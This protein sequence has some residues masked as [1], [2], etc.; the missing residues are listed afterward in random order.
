MA[1]EYVKQ[2]VLGIEQ[3]NNRIQ[4]NQISL[5]SALLVL[6][7]IARIFVAFRYEINWDEFFY[8]SLIYKFTNND[9]YA[10]LQTFH[11]HFFT[12]LTWITSN[13]VNQ[14]ISARLIMLLLQ[15]GTVFIIY[16]ISC[17]YL[18]KPAA[19]FA[20]L[21][22][23]AVSYNIRMGAS[24]RADP[25]ATFCLM[26]SLDLILTKCINHK[27]AL[28]AGSLIAISMMITIKSSLYL[29]T[30]FFITVALLLVSDKNKIDWQKIMMIIAASI[31]TFS[32]LYLY[33]KSS[34]SVIDTT[35]AMNT[36][37]DS[38]DKTISHYQLLPRERY[39]FNSFKLDIVYWLVLLYGLKT[40]CLNLYVP[41]ILSRQ[42]SMILLSLILPLCSVLFYRNAFPY[43]YPFML[44]PA[45]II[46]GVAWHS[47]QWNK[48]RFKESVAITSFVMFLFGL[49]II[50]NGFIVPHKKNL[51]RQREL[52]EVV[53]RAFPKPMPYFDRCSMIASF[54]QVGFFMSTWGVD[55]YTDNNQPIL[56]SAVIE[57][58]PPFFIANIGSLDIEQQTATPYIKQYAILTE[59]RETLKNNYIH[60]WGE[61][62]V[63]GKRLYLTQETLEFSITIPG[64]YT[65]E[66][67]SK[68]AIDGTALT[69]GDSIFLD[70]GNHVIESEFKNENYTLRWG[71]R[72]YRPTYQPEDRAI[73]S[74]F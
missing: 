55:D 38:F 13:E 24:F 45:S 23:F 39:L 68:A 20:A 69:P 58:T 2:G 10:S 25:L 4:L 22:Y 11:V 59:D 34:I 37:S 50:Y 14:I 47:I 65:L 3:T 61:L 9:L 44:A 26:A 72:L 6:A 19:L 54:P 51:D 27:R 12:W 56:K 31:C 7:T 21:S 36:I 18:N 30:F 52:I 71:D 64:F 42:A 74:G 29:P 1:N 15:V 17:R 70:S 33:H 40:V 32:L 66:S 53:H 46:C 60:H 57:Q 63:A 73:F 67:S 16:R 28:L 48:H 43:F 35:K 5:L 62:Y 49:S 8:L 41:T